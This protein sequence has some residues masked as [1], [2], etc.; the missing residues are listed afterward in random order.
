M[1]D[2][3]VFFHAQLI[4][5]AGNV[6]RTEQ[7]HQIIFQRKEELGR[8]RITLTAGTAAQLVINTAA[9][10]AFRTDNVQAAKFRHAFTKHN[11][12]TAACH[13][14]GNGYSAVLACFGD[15][16]RFFFMVFGV[17]YI[18]RYATTFEHCGKFFGLCDGSCAN[19]YWASGFMAFFN[20]RNGGFIFGAFCFIN[21]IRIVNT[22]HRFVGR[23]N[24][25]IQAVNFLEF[26]FFR[27]GGTSHAAELVVH[28]EVV[29]EGNSC[30]SLAFAFNFNSF[31]GFNSLMQA[32]GKA[33]AEHQTAGKFV[34]DNYLSVF[35]NVIPVAVHNGFG[36]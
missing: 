14:G 8:T 22:D 15:N 1:F 3:L 20:F 18:M 10:V 33:A 9:F 6:V 13:V 23:N 25:Y 17:K 26:L 21:N 28:T 4:H 35:Y 2:R 11:I 27:F 16:L 34:D 36:L 5:N 30:Q 12:G 32:F 7:A 24:N 31:F 29:L 19:Q